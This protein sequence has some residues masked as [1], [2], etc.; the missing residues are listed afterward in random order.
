MIVNMP[1]S[2]FLFFILLFWLQFVGVVVYGIIWILK[3]RRSKND[4]LE[5]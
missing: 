3:D 4:E 1:T 5:V 2:S